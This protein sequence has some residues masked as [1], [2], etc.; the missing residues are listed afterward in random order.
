MT[1]TEISVLDWRGVDKHMEA[2]LGTLDD[3]GAI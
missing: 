1:T 3:G 2:Q